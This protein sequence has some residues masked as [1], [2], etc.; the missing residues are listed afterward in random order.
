MLYLNQ[1][2]T[3]F[4]C[5]AIWK[6]LSPAPL[7][8]VSWTACHLVQVLV[9]PNYLSSGYFLPLE[10]KG[11][12]EG[13]SL[14]RHWCEVSAC[15]VDLWIHLHLSLAG[16]ANSFLTGVTGRQS[17]RWGALNQSPS[18]GSVLRQLLIQ[19]TSRK[20]VE[21]R[22]MSCSFPCGETESRFCR[23][24]R[25]VLV[26]FPVA[27]IKYETTKVTERKWVYFGGSLSPSWWPV[28]AAG[29]RSSWSHCSH[30]LEAGAMC[31]STRSSSFTAVC[32]DL[33]QRTVPPTVA[34]S[35][36]LS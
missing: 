31:A 36:Y 22:A 23:S 34:G 17:L 15:S 21:A 4:S 12:E 1:I 33:R 20:A 3:L 24:C 35:C 10:L 2:N 30:S 28:K 13:G 16:E 11:T 6:R 29:A 8:I 5:T 19:S 18:Q 7:S 32:Q 14:W 27:V 9:H 25:C 26:S